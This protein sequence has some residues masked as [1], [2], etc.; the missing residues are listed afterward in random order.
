MSA[1]EGV[2]TRSFFGKA[3]DAESPAGLPVL[4]AGY[5][6]HPADVELPEGVFTKRAQALTCQRRIEGGRHMYVKAAIVVEHH[7]ADQ[8]PVLQDAEG[9]TRAEA[10]FPY[11]WDALSSPLRNTLVIVNQQN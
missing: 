2:S 8:R 5:R 9:S 10:G 3:N 1:I 7:S 11:V 4:L 6:C